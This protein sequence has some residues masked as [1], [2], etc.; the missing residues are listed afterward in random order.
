MCFSATASF[1]AS[2][3]LIP[4]GIYCI[5]KASSLEKPYWAF[6][7]VPL[8]F[9]IQQIFE[10]VIWLEFEPGGGVATRLAALGFLFFSHLFWLFWVPFACYLV[11]ENATRK[12]LF[13]LLSMLGAAM[14]LSMYIPL[15]LHADWLS[16]VLTKLSIDY[17]TTLLYDGYVPRV[18]LRAIYAL[19]VIVPLLL[20]SDR[21]IKIFGVIIAISVAISSVFYSYAFI[22]VWCYFAALLSIYMLMMINK[23][24]KVA[25]SSVF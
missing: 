16:V 10:G 12:K 6:A 3:V 8:I 15:W 25:G 5:K 21:Y 17:K 22:S 13:F 24:S 18:I 14:G 1:A 4:A 11:E 9:G 20:A 19:I 7:V 23:K 2:V